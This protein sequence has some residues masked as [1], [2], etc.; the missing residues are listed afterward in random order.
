MT[1]GIKKIADMRAIRDGL[2]GRGEVPVEVE[3][4]TITLTRWRADVME[5]DPGV[6]D[7][8]KP[9]ERHAVTC[10][11]S[12]AVVGEGSRTV[13]TTD[14]KDLHEAVRAFVARAEFVGARDCGV[15]WELAA[16]LD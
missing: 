11:V 3:S 12:T 15:A 9:V 10:S 7:K 1:E 16:G 6:H 8:L 14:I 13:G 2:F 5:P 4:V